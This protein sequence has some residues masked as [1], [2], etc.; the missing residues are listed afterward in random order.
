MA[1]G[2]IRATAVER[3]LAAG[4][5]RGR[6]KGWQTYT[7]SGGIKARQVPDLVQPRAP[8]ARTLAFSLHKHSPELGGG[9]LLLGRGRIGCF[10]SSHYVWHCTCN[11]RVQ[12]MSLL[13]IMH[14]AYFTPL[15]I[16]YLYG[17]ERL[18]LVLYLACN[19][20]N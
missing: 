12:A 19:L 11:M 15:F 13:Y 14:I 6:A 5:P 1:S 9:C 20:R 16:Y 4:G 10:T 2:L 3:T 18:Y 17:R 7:S 8:A